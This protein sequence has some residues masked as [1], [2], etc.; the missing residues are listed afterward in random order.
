MLS[1]IETEIQY[2]IDWQPLSLALRALQSRSGP[3]FPEA[4]HAPSQLAASATCGTGLPRIELARYYVAYSSTLT[5]TTT[6]SHSN[7]LVPTHLRLDWC[8]R[9]GRY[10][11]P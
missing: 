6:P 1:I 2:S 5:T 7:S 10:K 3:R 11:V 9:L 4:V 8:H